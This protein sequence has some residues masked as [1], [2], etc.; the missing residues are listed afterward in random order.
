MV[1]PTLHLAF[2]GAVPDALHEPSAKPNLLVSYYYLRDFLPHRGTIEYASWIMDSGAFSAYNSGAVIDLQKYI[3]CCKELLASD[4]TLT[5][6]F[7]LDVIGDWKA[8]IRNTEEMWRQGVE[9]I[10]CYHIDEPWDV[11]IGLAKDY[12]KI[13]I[14]GVAYSTDALKVKYPQIKFAG[15]V[16]PGLF[17]QKLSWAHQC[18]ARVYPAKIHGF[19]FANHDAVLSLPFHSTDSSVWAVGL[20]AWGFS[21][22]FHWQRIN[23]KGKIST[24]HH[25]RKLRTSIRGQKPNLRPEIDWYMELERKAQAKW[26]KEMTKLEA[27]CPTKK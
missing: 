17:G 6:I 2:S 16:V 20:G 1:T 26:T 25:G 8:G 9:A 12:P 19:A 21:R 15:R 11:L 10:P 27:L 4:P 18:F 13:A 3:D 23:D 24:K 7:A 14:G 5:Q 22:A